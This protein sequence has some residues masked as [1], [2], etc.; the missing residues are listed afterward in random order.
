[1]N[2]EN[3]KV[4]LVEDD[5]EDAWLIKDMLKGSD[6][7]AFELVHVPRLERAL[8][9]LGEDSFDVVLLDLNLPD[10][11]GFDTFR[12]LHTTVPETAVVVLTGLADETLA[13]ETMREGGQDYLVKGEIDKKLLSRTLNYAIERKKAETEIR[14]KNRELETAN[15]MKSEFVSIVSHDFGNPLGIILGNTELLLM[16]AYG[17]L[18]PRAREKIQTISNIV[19]RLNRLRL[20]ILDLT[21]MELGK[22]GLNRQ[23]NNIS[24]LLRAIVLEQTATAAEKNQKIDFRGP[25]DVVLDYDQAQIFRVVENYLSN[26]IRYSQEGTAIDVGLEEN[27]K[28]VMIWV[29]DR[30]RGIPEDELEKVFLQFYRTGERVKGSTGLGLSIVKGIVS[31]HRGRCWA[32]SEGLGKGSTFYFTLPQERNS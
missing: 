20:D 13:M 5:T 15:R 18:S 28:E 7:Q 4:L 17:E 14:E 12:K 6:H 26:A 19:D 9:V 8:E 1:M 31:A 16:G 23:R 22:V 29:K 32:E 11:M 24:S 25:K 3:T 2:E 27:G 10:S 30:G 21:M